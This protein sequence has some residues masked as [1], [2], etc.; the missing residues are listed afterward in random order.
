[1]VKVG[2]IGG[3]GL[4]N[5]DILKSPEER[6]IETPYGL[7]SS[8]LLSGKLN[9]TDII[10]L[11]RHGRHHTIP[12]SEVNN[13]AN[14]S[15]L[16]ESGCTH[17]ISTTACGSLRED[18]GR[19][20][21]V[22]PDQFIDFTR[23]RSITFFSEFEPGKMKH[24]S[25]ADPFD[26]TLRNLI[27]SSASE[28]GLPVH[29]TGT[30]ITI[31]GPRFSTRA[32]SGMFR[33]WGADLVNMSVAPEAILAN[34]IGIP[35][36]AIAMSTDYDCWKEDEAPVSWEEVIAVFNKNVGNVLQLLIKVIGSIK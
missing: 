1:M 22:I 14:I 32:E 34:E 21:L 23:H 35:Y 5:P 8:S 9:G 16:K 6:N 31:E 3:S 20:D 33:I 12:P 18:I 24:T 36:A 28:I 29:K 17:I 30:V 2:I 13:R 19:G 10:I 27:I 7:P 4:E 11:S 25:M 15:A 26:R